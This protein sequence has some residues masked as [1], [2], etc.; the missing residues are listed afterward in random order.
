MKLGH[1][2]S[3]LFRGTKADIFEG[4]HRVPFIASWPGIIPGGT[5]T[6]RIV[7]LTDILGTCADAIGAKLP[8]DAAEDSISFTSEWAADVPKRRREA[9]VVQSSN[10]SF[11]IR[12]G[13]WKLCFCAGSGG[14]NVPRP[15]KEEAGLPRIQL[16]DLEQDIAEKMNL[17]DKHPEI[18]ERLTKL[19]EKSIEE[20]RSTPG[21]P[22]KNT[23]PVEFR[24]K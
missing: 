12:D 9:L 22:Q 17:Q 7:C 2:P 19:M 5:K 14:W 23:T 21:K 8:D 1:N 4:G 11:A 16:Y 3:H 18:V 13:K 10:G 24:K 20:G 15:G 6:D